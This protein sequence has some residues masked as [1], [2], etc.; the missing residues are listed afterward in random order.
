MKAIFLLVKSATSFLS[1]HGERLRIHPALHGAA[2]HSGKFKA[3][4]RS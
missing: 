3:K 4:A 2:T 1:L